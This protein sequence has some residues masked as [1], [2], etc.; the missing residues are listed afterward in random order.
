ME[1]T[2]IP[3]VGMA[4]PDDPDPRVV[5]A[6]ARR[7]APA[8]PARVPHTRV[9]NATTYHK[10]TTPPTPTTHTN[11]T[12]ATH[13][14]QD[15]PIRITPRDSGNILTAVSSNSNTYNYHVQAFQRGQPEVLLPQ[16]DG[17][18]PTHCLSRTRQRGGRQ[19]PGG[20]F[21]TSREDRHLVHGRHY[22][23]PNPLGHRHHLD[24]GQLCHEGVYQLRKDPVRRAP[25]CPRQRVL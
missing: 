12:S 16:E 22:Q 8:R 2:T 20:R 21:H 5:P 25:L 24:P 23:R 19:Q 9:A 7:V 1:D 10:K 11:T 18:H 6:R 15:G 13:A 14:A 3:H 4:I 17:V